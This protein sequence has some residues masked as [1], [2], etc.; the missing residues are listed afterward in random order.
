MTAPHAPRHD[1]RRPRRLAILIAVMSFGLTAP[2]LAQ[3]IPA[4]TELT[5]S[6]ATANPGLVGRR[7]NLVQER[8]TLHGDIDA[9]NGRCAAV[10]VGSLAESSCN[11][12]QAKL[13]AALASHI[14]GTT[15]FNAAAQTALAARGAPPPI[16]DPD[17][18]RVVNGIEALARRWRWSA[19]KLA[20]LDHNLRALDIDG[21][22]ASQDDIRQAW[23]DI[24]A[25]GQDP[26]LVREASQAGGLGF[27]GAGLQTTHQDCTIF[28]IANATGRPYG[29]VAAQ[30]TKIIS[31]GDWRD[32]AAR[33][34]PQA[35]I[36]AHGLNGGEVVLLAEI[37]G[38]GEV[39]PSAEFART[40]QDGRAVMVNVV[41][42]NGDFRFGHEVVL[43][44]SF[45]HD[46]QTW[47]VMRDS[48]QEGQARH[49][50]NGRELNTMLKE[51]GVAY[52]PN[53]RTT[54]GLL[55]EGGGE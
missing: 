8:A 1:D 3:T 23:R 4:L 35:A 27:A 40:L 5:V 36:E 29:F 2:V 12:D 19:A 34:A 18:A 15:A 32:R 16:M 49:F 50:V 43:T 54:P 24:L 14:A 21:P 11:D 48:Y 46:G 53:P 41:T 7:A 33:D 9:L 38:R 31:D 28:A 47:Y 52:R 22:I 45:Q 30:A 37:L 44:K 55:R 6:A 39:T 25:R 26:A 51:N 20:R 10:A 13:T 42:K 17:A